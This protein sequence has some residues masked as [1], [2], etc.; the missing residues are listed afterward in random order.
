MFEMFSMSAEGE[1]LTVSIF[2]VTGGS[3]GCTGGASRMFRV[4]LKR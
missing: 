1:S 4:A 3:S 2:L